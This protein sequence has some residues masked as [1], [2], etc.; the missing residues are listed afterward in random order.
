MYCITERQTSEGFH[1]I[2]CEKEV[3]HKSF[4]KSSKNKRWI[5]EAEKSKG[6]FFCQRKTFKK[7]TQLSFSEYFCLFAAVSCHCFMFYKTE[8]TLTDGHLMRS[9]LNDSSFSLFSSPSH[10]VC[11]ACCLFCM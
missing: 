7:K 11:L 8:H 10:S 4:N 6:R 3:Q 2:A 9:F 1:L 5:E